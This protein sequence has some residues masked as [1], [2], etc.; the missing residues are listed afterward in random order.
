MLILF[1]WDSGCSSLNVTKVSNNEVCVGTRNP[2]E[3]KA[4]AFQQGT[5]SF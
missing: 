2:F 1:L 4:Q 3:P 5:F